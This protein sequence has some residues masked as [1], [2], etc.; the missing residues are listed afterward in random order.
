MR[1]MAFY[2]FKCKHLTV[3]LFMYQI[4]EV[5]CGKT[6]CTPWFWFVKRAKSCCCVVYRVCSE[7]TSGAMFIYTQIE[8]CKSMFN[9][10]VRSN[11]TNTTNTLGH[12]WHVQEC[13]KNWFLNV[14]LTYVLK[15]GGGNLPPGFLFCNSISIY[16]NIWKTWAEFLLYIYGFSLPLQL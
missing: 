4:V 13:T 11:E 10:K 14:L 1:K 16:F 8:L 3:S 7:V 2:W 5:V 12:V 15:F 6:K 9:H